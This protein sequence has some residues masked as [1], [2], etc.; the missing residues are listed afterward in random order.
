MRG[1]KET[2]RLWVAAGNE[3]A[4]E[5]FD[6]LFTHDTVDHVSG[7]TGI[8]WWKTVFGWIGASFPDWQ[9]TNVTVLGEGELV[10]F[11]G[12]LTATHQGSRLPFLAGIEATGV[13]IVWQHQHLFRLEGGRIAE[14]WATRDDLGV[15][16]Q[17]GVR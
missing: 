1:D 15:L 8:D 10:A 5:R 17:L 6:R 13:P 11:K 3:R 2:V 7:N 16:R 9:W 12:D 14:H 4:F